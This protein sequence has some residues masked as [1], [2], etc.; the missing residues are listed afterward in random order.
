MISLVFNSVSPIRFSLGKARPQRACRLASFRYGD[1]PHPWVVSPIRSAHSTTR[2]WKGQLVSLQF[3]KLASAPL[4][5]RPEDCGTIPV[6]GQNS[7]GI[8]INTEIDGMSQVFSRGSKEV[9]LS[10]TIRQSVP[11]Q[12]EHIRSHP[13]WRDMIYCCIKQ[14]HQIVFCCTSHKEFHF[15]PRL[16]PVQAVFFLPQNP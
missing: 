10:Q 8:R 16:T 1:R 3:G 5:R 11:R 9:S 14:T 7:T 13:R 15:Y 12:S 4:V 6:A 2:P